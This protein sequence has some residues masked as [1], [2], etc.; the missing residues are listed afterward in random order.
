MVKKNTLINNIILL[1]ILQFFNYLAPFLVLPYLTRI[2]SSDSFGEYIYFITIGQLLV[3]FLGL[4]FDLSAPRKIS[5]RTDNKY[6][7]YFTSVCLLKLIFLS[8]SIIGLFFASLAIPNITF[9]SIFCLFFTGLGLI[10]TPQWF[11]VSIQKM[12]MVTFSGIITKVI[13]IVFILVFIKNDN[14]LNYIYFLYAISYAIP[15]I[16]CMYVLNKSYSLFTVPSKKYTWLVFL[17]T[18]P[19]FISRVA[20][21]TYTVSC[22]LVVGT[23]LGA[24]ALSTYAIS[25]KLYVAAQSLIYPITNAL[26]PYMAK[27]RNLSIAKKILLISFIIS[28]IGVIIGYNIS[29]ALI[30]LIFGDFYS[31]SYTVL[32][33]FII[34]L[35]FVF[36]SIIIG[37]PILSSFGKSNITNRSVFCGVI[38]FT[39]LTPI[40]IIT[41]NLT[42]KSMAII[43]LLSEISVFLIRFIFF[44]KYFILGKHEKSY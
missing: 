8:L 31:T 37:Y 30:I 43:V 17:D 44:I 27:E 6:K 24:V 29:E 5:R 7:N 10:F 26:Y 14:D 9:F 19:F 40:I 1:F 11:F 23:V 2:L 25:E 3:I 4:G 20:V 42:P 34:T 32:N 35:G 15:A 12:K 33:I 39:V 13:F 41:G 36:P 18:L 16:I 28:I 38:V 22:G 21:S